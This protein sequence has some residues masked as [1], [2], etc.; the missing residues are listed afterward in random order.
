MDLDSIK[1]IGILGAGT[2]GLRIGLRC[3]LDGYEV[4]IY[5]ISPKQ[6]DAAQRT[7]LKL[8]GSLEKRQQISGEQSVAALDRLIF[9]TNKNQ[10]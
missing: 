9:T 8:L 6:I 5:D 1:K 4:C 2:L 7:Q 10:K 3:A